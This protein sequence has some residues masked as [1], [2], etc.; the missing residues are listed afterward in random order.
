MSDVAHNAKTAAE[1]TAVV[2][3]TAV[4][5]TLKKG[6]KLD[7]GFV[8]LDVVDL[9]ELKA[10][11]IWAKHEK[12]GAEVFHALNDDSENLFALPSPL[13]RRTTQARRIF[14]NT[15]CFAAPSVIR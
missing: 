11:G 5:T 15:R 13:F 4:K 2:K 10:E 7:S 14:L 3:T 8:I 1:K 6:Q 9:E 12:S